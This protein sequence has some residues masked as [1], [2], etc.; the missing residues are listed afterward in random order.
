M[1]NSL[2]KELSD[3]GFHIQ[4]TGFD[5]VGPEMRRVAPVIPPISPHE[6]EPEEEQEIDL[7]ALAP[8]AEDARNAEQIRQEAMGE[9]PDAMDTARLQQGIATSFEQA[10]LSGFTASERLRGAPAG[11][12]VSP[13]D[14][15]ARMYEAIGR[16][17]C[18]IQ[19]YEDLAASPH[20][21][22]FLPH[23]REHDEGLNL[24]QVTDVPM[25]PES[26]SFESPEGLLVYNGLWTQNRG[27]GLWSDSF[28]KGACSVAF[29]VREDD[30]H[31]M[32]QL[33]AATLDQM[34]A[35]TRYPAISDLVVEKCARGGVGCH[36]QRGG[37]QPG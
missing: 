35:H 24:L 6:P 23:V 17:L 30:L 10:V 7:D 3:E 5:D 9:V 36:G 22:T 11:R 29:M 31:L 20:L 4:L 25:N 8:V 2:R 26:L 16:L 33:I 21:F 34:D 27:S 28:A 37:Y 19:D 1:I 13:V 15:E 12:R 18:R 32:H 14:L